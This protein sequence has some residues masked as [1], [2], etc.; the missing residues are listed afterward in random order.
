MRR[1][2]PTWPPAR[3]AAR[4]IT[5]GAR[6]AHLPLIWRE[7]RARE[8]Y[9]QETNAD[10]E[11][12]GGGSYRPCRK[13]TTNTRNLS[14][15]LHPLGLR[16]RDGR[17]A[18]VDPGRWCCRL[19]HGHPCQGTAA[20]CHAIRNPVIGRT[21]SAVHRGRHRCIAAEEHAGWYAPQEGAMAAV[22]YT[23]RASRR[24][25]SDGD[26]L[27]PC[28]PSPWPIGVGNRPLAQWPGYGATAVRS[29][30]GP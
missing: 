15:A 28:R 14:R 4:K 27:G 30:T 16:V 23:R 17:T 12:G 18:A 7:F 19:K 5:A 20:L 29:H 26:L 13:A 22:V 9:N 3:A 6:C 1:G 21:G 10:C 24:R 25:F 8:R 11:G 2:G